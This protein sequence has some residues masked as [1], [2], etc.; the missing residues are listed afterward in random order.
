MSDI[1]SFEPDI[2]AESE[3]FGVWSTEEEEGR[4]YHIEF[5]SVTIHMTTEEWEEFLIMMKSA[6]S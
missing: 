6:E 4:L 2:I 5:G 3:N 1:E